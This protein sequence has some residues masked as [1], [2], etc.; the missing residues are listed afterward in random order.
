MKIQIS[1][2]AKRFMEDRGIEDVTFRLI[3]MCVSG[4]FGMVKEIEPRYDAPKDSRDY[5][6]FRGEN[7]HVFVSRKV[8]IIGPLGLDTEGLWRMKRLC[9]N[10]VTV[11]I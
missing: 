7:C 9:L 4:C 2:S 10:G 3:A 11:P 1:K 6:Y 8:K 5:R